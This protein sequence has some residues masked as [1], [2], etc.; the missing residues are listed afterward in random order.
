MQL[1]GHTC[2]DCEIG[3]KQEWKKKKSAKVLKNFLKAVSASFFRM[4][5]EELSL[6]S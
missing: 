1:L 2:M 5:S 4:I 3:S 6:S